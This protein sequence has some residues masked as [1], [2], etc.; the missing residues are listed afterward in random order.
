MPKS[1]ELESADVLWEE[2]SI[3]LT[4]QRLKAQPWAKIYETHFTEKEQKCCCRERAELHVG[5][6]QAVFAYS[7]NQVTVE[8]AGGLLDIR[9]KV[10][11][12][13]WS[14]VCFFSEHFV[15]FC[16]DGSED[17][18]TSGFRFSS[19]VHLCVKGSYQSFFLPVYITTLLS[20]CLY[21]FKTKQMQL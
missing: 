14:S 2:P 15:C 7:C 1:W 17:R 12:F 13:R 19:R 6:R 4:D 8:R 20:S 3:R 11:N 9:S 5:L 18:A 16:L 21:T 10:S